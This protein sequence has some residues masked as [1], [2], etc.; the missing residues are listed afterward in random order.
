[1]IFSSKK[2]ESFKLAV[3]IFSTLRRLQIIKQLI[4]Q[5]SEKQ[6]FSIQQDS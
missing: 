3:Q 2:I 1:M 4:S 6:F 5:Q